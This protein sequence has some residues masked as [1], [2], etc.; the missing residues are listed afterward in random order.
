MDS[1]DFAA[2]LAVM[3]A[4]AFVFGLAIDPLIWIVMFWV[5]LLTGI[6]WWA[7]KRTG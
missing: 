2:I 4:A 7:A 1:M 5:L 3:F 6:G